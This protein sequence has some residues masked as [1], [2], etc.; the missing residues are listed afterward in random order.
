MTFLPYDKID[1]T[2]RLTDK[3]IVSKLKSITDTDT[4]FSFKKLFKSNDKS[5]F[6]TI[7]DESFEIKR[8]IYYKNSFLP[9]LFGSFQKTIN[10]ST[11][12]IKMRMH[13]AVN[14]GLS[15]ICSFLLFFSI[16]FLL[17]TDKSDEKEITRFIPL[18]MFS[19]IY[20]LVMFFYKLESKKAQRDLI[21]LLSADIDK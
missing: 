9:I 1:L 20:V 10:G 14:I 19:I 6:G 8:I 21:E 4:K 2:T 13:M 15:I 3:Q 18:I 7:T 5:Y 17:Y 16:G 11:I 12:S